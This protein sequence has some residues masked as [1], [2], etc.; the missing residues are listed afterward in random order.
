MPRRKLEKIV[1]KLEDAR[2]SIET[3]RGE[4]APGK[5]D[6]RLEEVEETLEEVTDELDEVADGEQD[7]R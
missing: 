1:G 3:V 7:E 6:E 5:D 4:S 2:E